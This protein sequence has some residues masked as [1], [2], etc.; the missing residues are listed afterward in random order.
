GEAPGVYGHIIH[1]IESTLALHTI[2]HSRQD[3]VA[4]ESLWARSDLQRDDRYIHEML[5]C[6]LR[7]VPAEVC[8]HAE[9]R[10]DLSPL[11][12][13]HARVLSRLEPWISSRVVNCEREARSP[14]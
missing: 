14:G 7:Q 8:T 10:I 5:Y 2:Q 9:Q 11:Q 1:T 13:I 6:F 4:H 3:N 12:G